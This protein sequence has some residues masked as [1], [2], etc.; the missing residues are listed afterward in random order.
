MNSAIAAAVGS[1][2]GALVSYMVMVLLYIA[3][4]E[5]DLPRNMHCELTA[6]ITGDKNE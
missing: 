4:C 5:R 2:I 1:L 3:P 6:K